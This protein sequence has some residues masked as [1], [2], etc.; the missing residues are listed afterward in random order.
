MKR[1]GLIPALLLIAWLCAQSSAGATAPLA[2]PTPIA[3][4][5][6][7]GGSALP[8]G[9]SFV[10]AG[11]VMQQTP[12]GIVPRPDLRLRDVIDQITPQDGVP[13][14]SLYG[15]ATI[16]RVWD[17]H[18]VPYLGCDAKGPNGVFQFYVFN[19]NTQQPAPLQ[20]VVTG[21]GS[22]GYDRYS[23]QLF[24]VAWQG[25]L[26]YSGPIVGSAPYPPFASAP[27]S[28]RQYLPGVQK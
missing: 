4:G 18:G 28:K 5:V 7:P 8:P 14:Y 22:I 11:T 6:P 15:G 9:Y 2:P 13:G 27:L 10:P 19:L 12:A 20:F 26:Y 1:L 3:I 23:G 24:W 17:A 16:S 25:S 21:R